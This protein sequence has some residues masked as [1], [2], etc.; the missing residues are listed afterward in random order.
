ML[1]YFIFSKA[2]SAP[3]P[4]TVSGL[5]VKLNFVPLS[6]IDVNVKHNVNSPTTTTTTTRSNY[7]FYSEQGIRQDDDDNDDENMSKASATKAVQRSIQHLG[8]LLYKNVVSL[9]LLFFETMNRYMVF[10]DTKCRHCF[11]SEDLV[12]KKEGDELVD[13]SEFKSIKCH[14]KVYRIFY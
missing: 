14:L 9:S 2:S 7:L 5:H 4:V 3:T 11:I 6:G 1:T 10:F 13:A 12:A 8:S